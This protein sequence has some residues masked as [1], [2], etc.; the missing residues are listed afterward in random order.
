M[1]TR[2]HPRTLQEAFP[3]DHWENAIARYRRPLA[4]RVA[5]VLL[6]VALGLGLACTLFFSLSA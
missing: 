6:A 5:D 1:T 4:Q 3:A 2:R